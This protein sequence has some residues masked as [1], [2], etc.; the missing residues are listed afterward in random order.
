MGY[1]HISLLSKLIKF[2][3]LQDSLDTNIAWY[4][5]TSPLKQVRFIS[6]F[7]SHRYEKGENLGKIKVDFLTEII[8]SKKKN[9]IF[10]M[11]SN[12]FKGYNCRA[13]SKPLS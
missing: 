10:L 13:L 5:R 8:I 2:F 11:K 12:Y 3:V 9:S 7:I 6:L 4:A 1:M